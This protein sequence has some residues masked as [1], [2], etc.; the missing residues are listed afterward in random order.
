MDLAKR[1]IL[2]A[3]E[4]FTQIRAQRKQAAA[5]IT[6]CASTSSSN[7]S[8]SSCSS[9]NIDE[10]QVTLSVK[11][12]YHVVGLVVGPKGATIKRIQQ[13]TNT[14]IVT[15]SRDKEPHFQVTGSKDN[16][17][18][19]RIEIDHYIAARTG[20]TL[21]SEGELITPNADFMYSEAN[22]Q[23]T[24]VSDLYLKPGLPDRDYSLLTVSPPRN[25]SRNKTG[26]LTA[27]SSPSR[28]TCSE[29]SSVWQYPSQLLDS[30]L[31]LSSSCNNS[32]NSLTSYSS[33]SSA[34]TNSNST[35]PKASSTPFHYKES[36][37][38]T[39]G[40]FP[41]ANSSLPN[42]SLGT[43]SSIAPIGTKYFPKSLKPDS[44]DEFPIIGNMENQ[45]TD[46]MQEVCNICRMIVGIEKFALIPCGHVVACSSCASSFYCHHCKQQVKSFIK[47]QD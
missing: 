3:A 38:F 25:I 44:N 39:F 11:V 28:S 34:Q 22:S 42:E 40:S 13:K 16:V 37:S 46:K 1:E 26:M 30:S 15:P 12:P 19:A 47:L 35:I 43:T 36:S 9:S 20:T 32:Y 10:D 24:M 6:R 45:I 27:L 41:T 5:A 31:L 8:S 21:T 4:H 14:Y 17:D 7:S 18:Q 23:N 29:N 33:L 2:A